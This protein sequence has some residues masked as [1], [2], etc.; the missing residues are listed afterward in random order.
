MSKSATK[1][2]GITLGDPEGIGAEV[3]KKA[4]L[5]CKLKVPH[6]I[7]LIGDRKLFKGL[8][9]P[10]VDVPY[11]SAAEGSFKFLERSVKLIQGEVI[12]ALVTAP[13]S[14]ERVHMYHKGFCGHTEYLAQAFQVRQ[15]DMMFIAPGIRLS[16]VTR[17]VPLNKVS[18]MITTRAVLSTIQLMHLTLKEQF[19]IKKPKIAVLGLNPHAGESGLLGLEDKREIIPAINQACVQ[20][21]KA[22]GPFPADTFFINDRGFDGIVAMY[23]DQGLAPLKGMYFKNLVNFTAGLPFVRTSPVHGT[24]FDIAG[25]GIADPSSMIAAIKL[26]SELI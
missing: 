15:F 12:D 19:R 3:I 17:H 25:K 13:L 8:A 22:F 11:K 2:I 16:L 24:A 9:F 20:G 1:I 6:Q 10:V 7:V 4:L 26:A 21:I 5:K 14:K 23:H 18:K